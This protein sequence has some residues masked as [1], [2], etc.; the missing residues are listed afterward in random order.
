MKKIW[1]IIF[2][3]I[4]ILCLASC[5]KS[6]EYLMY[7][8][9]KEKVNIRD[10]QDSL[11]LD[12]FLE[13][14]DVFANKLTIETFYDKLNK[15]ELDLS[16]TDNYCISPISV[17]MA[18]AMAIECSNGNTKDEILSAVGVT[19]EEVAKFT[20]YLYTIANNERYRTDEITNA[21]KLMYFEQLANSIWIDEKVELKPIG[22]ENLAN[23][24]H[25][26]S[27]HAPFSTNKKSASKA[28]N[29]YIKE[30]TK[31]LIDPKTEYSKDTLFLLINTYYIKDVWNDEGDDLSFT[32]HKYDFK[33]YDNDIE[34]INLLE[35]YYK[36]GKVFEGINYKQFYTETDNGNSITFVVPNDGV[37]IKDVYT[38]ENLN[39]F[40]QTKYQVV[41]EEEKLWYQTR[42]LFPEYKTE[43]DGDLKDVFKEKLGVK[44]LFEHA[45]L[46]NIT[47]GDVYCE[48]IYHKTKLI[49]DKT[50]IEGAAVTIMP[51]CG[52][53]APDETYT[54]VYYDFIV[55]R[56]FIF[57]MKNRYDVT[58]FSGI[59]TEI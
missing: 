11:E 57:I 32:K 12:L 45:D 15:G 48:G 34:K 8:A 46:S 59:I 30:M 6:S 35:G 53:A 38:L 49:V 3:L 51:M 58:L 27:Y 41:N 24:Y 5:N 17:Y 1:G 26:S 7:E 33:E 42:S 43:F 55:D 16:S 13:K 22:L 31:G 36:S 29:D 19:Y 18:L 25:C 47:D 37:N 2:I 10:Y 56:D 39:T 54:K 14:L 23:L 52:E 50:G 28:V 40:T 9:S 4:S 20:E 21:K 44:V